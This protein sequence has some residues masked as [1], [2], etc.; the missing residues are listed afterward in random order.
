M[1]TKRL[2]LSPQAGVAPAIGYYLAAMNEVREQLREAVREM[3]NEELARQAF[4]GAHAIGALVLH[5]GEA[6]W[7]WMQCIL[8]GHE[9]TDEDRQSP[10]WDVLVEP[11][12]F[13]SKNYSA[14]FCLDTIDEIRGQTTAMLASFTDADLE[15]TFKHTRGEK[16]IEMSLRW[17]LHHL[18]DHEA[19]H[20]GQILMLKRMLGGRVETVLD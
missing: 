17:V 11:D 4:K 18:L 2:I 16:T 10:F 12:A 19:Q 3:S 5:I 7:W 6:E 20:K 15:R 14:Q 9:L 8:S 1:K 13:P